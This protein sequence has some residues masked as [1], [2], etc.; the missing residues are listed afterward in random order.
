MV[1]VK[2]NQIFI[3]LTILFFLTTMVS[4]GYI[5][6]QQLKQVEEKV[7]K[8]EE[9]KVLNPESTLVQSLYHSVVLRED[10]SYKYFMYENQDQYF[11]Q[12]ASEMSKL[13]L[14]YHNLKIADLK[15]TVLIDSSLLEESITIPQSN[16]PSFYHCD[17]NQGVITLIPYESMLA[18]YQS[19]FGEE[20]TLDTTIPIQT[21]VNH[22]KYYVFYDSLNGYIPYVTE[23]GGTS[24][25]YFTGEVTQ[26]LQKENEIQIYEEV[27][28]IP[29]GEGIEVQEPSIYVYTFQVTE[30][31][32]TFISRVKES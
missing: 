28:E 6:S 17:H 5:L 8:E 31:G 24:G 23:G 29:L 25:S 12:D 4:V 32:Y 2:K 27:T 7:V 21:D 18:T 19:L 11:V 14:A 3:L 13:T 9:E 15:T 16:T 26:A 20:E 1:F 30:D 22:I 10:T